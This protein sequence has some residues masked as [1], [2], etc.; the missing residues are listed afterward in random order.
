MRAKYYEQL[1]QM[2]TALI[3]MG[4]FTESALEG[5]ASALT[6]GKGIKK[7]LKFE[8]KSDISLDELERLSVQLLLT[9]Q[10]V[11]SDLRYISSAI[12]MAQNL[13]RIS[14]LA[15]DMT[16]IVANTP[17]CINV[18][19]ITKMH[20]L[21]S[22]M[23]S[24]SINAFVQNDYKLAE[25]LYRA[26]DEVDELFIEIKKDLTAL[27]EQNSEMASAAMNM[28]L[29]AKCVE[30]IAD[31]ACN[32]SACTLYAVTGSMRTSDDIHS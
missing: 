2:N 29:L 30:R 20:S 9:Q 22:N 26:D 18:A 7:T 21:A 28:L 24:D 23:V 1:E 10:P 14:D 5:A 25:S 17:K 19:K 27:I 12:R 31:H 32:I 16:D 4:S 13:E 11:A 3:R 6:T 8:K 15:K